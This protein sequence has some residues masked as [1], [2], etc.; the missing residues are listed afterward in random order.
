M[1]GYA[2]TARLGRIEPHLSPG[3]AGAPPPSAS[4][5]EEA[6]ETVVPAT[7]ELDGRPFGEAFVDWLGGLN[8]ACSQTFFYLFDPN[9]WR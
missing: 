8:R 6:L 9:S 5:H 4:G 7:I 2:V 3:L 1:A